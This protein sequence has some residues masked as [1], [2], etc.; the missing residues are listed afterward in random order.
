MPIYPCPEMHSQVS[1]AFNH[2]QMVVPKGSCIVF[3]IP[4][5]LWGF[6]GSDFIW[7]AVE[8]VRDEKLKI[9]C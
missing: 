5:S 8:R 6:S 9:F 3:L 1:I 7:G 4:S 2:K